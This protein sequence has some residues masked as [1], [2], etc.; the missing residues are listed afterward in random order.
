M[1]FKGCYL[2]GKDIGNFLSPLILENFRN[3]LHLF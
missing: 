3:H 2:N 1:L